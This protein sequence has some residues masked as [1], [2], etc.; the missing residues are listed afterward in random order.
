M[1][2]NKKIAIIITLIFS[3]FIYNT[4][5]KATTTTT[6]VINC[7]NY[8]DMKT[9]EAISGKCRWISGT[10]QAQYVAEESCNNNNIRVVLKLFGIIVLVAKIV[11]PLIIIG[12]GVIDMYK[13][14]IDKD[15]KSLAKQTQR[16]LT[17]ILTGMVVFLIPN[18]VSL[19]FSLSDKLNIIDTSDYKTCAA[20][21]ID[22]TNNNSCK[23]EEV[24]KNN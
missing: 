7:N 5:V 14:V 24:F 3:F 22:P 1:N 10:C 4:N 21:V 11:V 18:I 13:A 6:T 16:L 2:M 8:Q 15:E 12:Y 20:C 9:C 19:V 17:R 23:T